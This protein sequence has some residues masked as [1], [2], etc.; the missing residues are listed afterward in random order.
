MIKCGCGANMEL[1]VSN[2]GYH[3]GQYCLVCSDM[4]NKTHAHAKSDWFRKKES[5]EAVL[6]EGD[7]T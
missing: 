4:Y 1:F 6:E 2:F 7:Q 3:E 5:L